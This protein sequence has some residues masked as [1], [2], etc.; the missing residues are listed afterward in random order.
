MRWEEVFAVFVVCHLAGDF[1]LQTD[2][3]AVNKH[4]G[5]SRDRTARRALFSHAL[6]YTI[7]FVPAVVWIATESSALAIALL[8]VIFIPHL[9][10][11]DA[12]VLIAW[13]R[14]VKRSDLPPGQPVYMAVDQAFHLVF[15][16]GTALLATA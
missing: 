12:R 16:F 4:N 1:V 7:V 10:Q 5:L 6:V 2:W 14:I 11:D 13:N 9:V 3:Q 15:L 8:A